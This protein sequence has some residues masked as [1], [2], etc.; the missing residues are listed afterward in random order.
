MSRPW[1]SVVLVVLSVLAAGCGGSKSGNPTAPPPGGGGGP[2]YDFGPL[3][4][5]QS[6]LQTFPTA[7]TFGYRCKPHAG[8]GMTGS[9]TV[10]NGSADSALVNVGQGN[11]LQFA[12]GSVT[13]KPGG[14]VRWVNVSNMTNHTVTSN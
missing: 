7:G 8:S 5:G 12:P 13:I 14:Y 6:V 2:A 10:S 1:F 4:L 11:A 3:A 9:V